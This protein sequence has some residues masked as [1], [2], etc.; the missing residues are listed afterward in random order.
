MFAVAAIAALAKSNSAYILH[1]S[2]GSQFWYQLLALL[3]TLV[4]AAVGGA[5]VALL[6]KLARH[7]SVEELK[8]EHMYE[9]K[10]ST[11]WPAVPK[12]RDCGMSVTMGPSQPPISTSSRSSI[13]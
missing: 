3:V 1:S 13:L 7:P 5:V 12:H 9:D 6:V 4:I 8:V 10:G 2:K 11:P